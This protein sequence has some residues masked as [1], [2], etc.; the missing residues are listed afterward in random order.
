MELILIYARIRRFILFLRILYRL[1]RYSHSLTRSSKIRFFH[2]TFI[3]D[4]RKCFF[5][6]IYSVTRPRVAL[7]ALLFQQERPL[8]YKVVMYF[9]KA[10]CIKVHFTIV[11][12]FLRISYVS[13]VYER[14]SSLDILIKQSFPLVGLGY[15]A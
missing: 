15:N 11:E 4:T 2:R 12:V 7:R 5:L 1:W 8:F 10:F 13:M 14:F 6:L 3:I 9:N